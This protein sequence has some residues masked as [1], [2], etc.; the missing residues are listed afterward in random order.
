MRP[1][2]K[3]LLSCAALLVSA[4]ACADDDD[5]TIGVYVGAGVGQAQIRQDVYQIDAH[6]FGWKLFGGWRPLEYLGAEVEYDDL[7]KKK[8]TYS[9]PPLTINT[10]SSVAGLY[11]VGYLPVP[12][13]WLDLF[14]KAGAARV[15]ADTDVQPTNLVDD[16]TRTSF[17][18]GAGLQFK[19]G[20]PAVRI[21]YQRFE[22]SQGTNALLTLAAT[23]NF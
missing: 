11:A 10:K 15:K 14:A 21:E 16:S 1:L 7:G 23:A 18:W 17:A 2:P 13:P 4:A 22:G 12:E 9:N 3:V 5:D 19:F 20:I 8:A 6:A